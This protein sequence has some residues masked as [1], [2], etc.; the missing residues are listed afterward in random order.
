MI[1]AYY[2]YKTLN[3]LLLIASN[4]FNR[5]Y[6]GEAYKPVAWIEWVLALIFAVNAGYHL[7]KYA[8]SKLSLKP[9]TVTQRQKKLLGVSDHDPMFKVEKPVTQKPVEPSPSRNFSCANLSLHSSSFGTP[10]LNDS[11]T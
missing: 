9:V 7:V 8:L 3:L 6:G 10:I 1:L 2:N 4:S 11:C 5:F